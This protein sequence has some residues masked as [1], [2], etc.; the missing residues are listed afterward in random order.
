M[1]GPP[2]SFNSLCGHA[3]PS[4]PK[5]IS[6][7]CSFNRYVTA[8]KKST[9]IVF[10]ILKLKNAAIWLVESIFAFN[11]AHLKLHDQFAALID[12]KLHAQNQLYISISFWDVK[13][14]KASLILG[15]IW[16]FFHKLIFSSNFAY[17]ATVKPQ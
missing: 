1:N 8:C 7:I 16:N 2:L 13:V 14:L 15:R 17:K 10:E 4:P 5:I 9:P 6:S 11:Y 3:W 12:M